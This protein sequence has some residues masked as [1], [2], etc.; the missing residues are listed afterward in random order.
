MQLSRDDQRPERNVVFV[1]DRLAYYGMN[2]AT[3]SQAVRNRIDGL[4]ASK[5]REDGD[6][7][8]I[9]VR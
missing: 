1:R 5:Y 9:I 2:S 7:Y 6:E 8:A 4:V 3:A